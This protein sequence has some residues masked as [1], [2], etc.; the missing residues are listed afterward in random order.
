MFG[1]IFL[2]IFLLVKGTDRPYPRLRK[3]Q[4]RVLLPAWAIGEV[5]ALTNATLKIV[6]KV[7][8]YDYFRF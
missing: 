7:R 2:L 3:F 1:F 6:L 5:I 8:I 4:H